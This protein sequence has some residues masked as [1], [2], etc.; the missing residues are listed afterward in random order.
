MLEKI[1]NALAIIGGIA[2]S[3]LIA[4]DGSKSLAIIG[5]ILFLISASSA[6]ALQWKHTSQRGLMWLNIYF[7]GINIFGL[8]RRLT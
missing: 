6:V 4:F 7:V 1:L 2:G 8:L 5:Y 3:A